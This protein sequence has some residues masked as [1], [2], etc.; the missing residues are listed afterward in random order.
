MYICICMFFV[1]NCTLG[2][3]W[4]AWGECE[5]LNGISGNGTRT[6]YKEELL[7]SRNGGDCEKRADQQEQ[8]PCIKDF[9][10]GEFFIRF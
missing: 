4:A 6:R 1:A 5:P 3:E 10:T 8:E 9:P 2:R 7:S